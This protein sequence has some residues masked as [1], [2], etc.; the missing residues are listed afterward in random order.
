MADGC[1]LG[2]QA[3]QKCEVMLCAVCA[4]PEEMNGVFE[5]DGNRELPGLAIPSDRKSG[6]GHQ[7]FIP[8]DGGAGVIHGN[9]SGNGFG[10]QIR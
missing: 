8:L 9:E 7:H 1:H 10:R 4:L 3:V 6:S 2:A 5:R